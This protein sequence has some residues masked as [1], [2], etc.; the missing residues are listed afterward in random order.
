MVWCVCMQAQ[1]GRR[2]T[3]I[4]KLVGSRSVL[5]VKSYARQYFKHKVILYIHIT[6]QFPTIFCGN[7]CKLEFMSHYLG[8]K[9]KTEHL[10][11]FILIFKAKSEP[12]AAASSAGLL[13]I[14]NTQPASSTL[15]NTVRIEK[16]SDEEDEEVDIT[17]ELCNHGDSDHK[18]PVDSVCES[19]GLEGIQIRAENP[20]EEQNKVGPSMSLDH[21]EQREETGVSEKVSNH[22][23]LQAAALTSSEVITHLDESQC[24]QTESSRQPGQL[25]EGGSDDTGKTA[26]MT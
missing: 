4:A 6:L 2:W 5:Q 9:I 15:A 25:E 1:F 10:L 23:H 17:D 13:N 26:A 7:Q 18:P 24:F 3:K 14:Q 20:K 8:N 22:G 16:L 19:E 11:F 12:K 21:L